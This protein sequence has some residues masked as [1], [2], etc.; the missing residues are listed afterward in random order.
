MVDELPFRLCG[1]D[2]RENEQLHKWAIES[3]TVLYTVGARVCFR[4]RFEIVEKK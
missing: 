4:G 1:K 2:K 3:T